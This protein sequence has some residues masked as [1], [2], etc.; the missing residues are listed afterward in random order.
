MKQEDQGPIAPLKAG[1]EHVHV[2]A[3]DMS[4]E[5]RTEPGGQ[6]AVFERSHF[7]QIRLPKNQWRVSW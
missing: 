4:Q 3:I 2:E 1:L 5:A 6:N 7:N